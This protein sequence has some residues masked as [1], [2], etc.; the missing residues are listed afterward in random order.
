MALG[1]DNINGPI[2]PLETRKQINVERGRCNAVQPVLAG[3]APGTQINLL[4]IGN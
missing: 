4:V 2:A 1:R 3:V